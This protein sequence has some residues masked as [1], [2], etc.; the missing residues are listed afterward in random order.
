MTFQAKRDRFFNNL[1]IIIMIVLAVIILWPVGYEVFYEKE[2]DIVA[3]VMM[4]ITFI[5]VEG[6]II[7]I[8]FDIEYTF[9]DPFEVA[10]VM[11]I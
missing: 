1:I 7:W 5:I 2:A 4:I 10:Y 9:N 3:V 11:K 6:L 8:W